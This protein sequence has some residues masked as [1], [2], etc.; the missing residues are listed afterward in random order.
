MIAPKRPSNSSRSRADDLHVDGLHRRPDFEQ[1]RCVP[2][3]TLMLAYWCYPA[4][5]RRHCSRRCMLSARLSSP[6][7]RVLAVR[8][9]L[10]LVRP[11]AP[12]VHQLIGP[13]FR[14]GAAFNGLVT[15]AMTADRSRSASP[16]ASKDW[17]CKAAALEAGR[18]FLQRAATKGGRIV[19]APDKDADGLSAG[20]RCEARS[21]LSY[22]SSPC[23]PCPST[24]VQHA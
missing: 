20:A 12:S 19:L 16:E 17:P 6:L 5:T 10:C 14:L 8:N 23:I 13:S 18:Q 4:S 11:R 22:S 7:Y 3:A 21:N 2:Q 15:A 1:A 9:P 24:N